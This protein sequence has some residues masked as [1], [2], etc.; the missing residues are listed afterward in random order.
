M[1]RACEV[2]QAG[3]SRGGRTRDSLYILNNRLTSSSHAH[4][5]HTIPRLVIP[6]KLLLQPGQE[7]RTSGTG[8]CRAGL[9]SSWEWQAAVHICGAETEGARRAGERGIST[10]KDAKHALRACGG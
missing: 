3:G 7:D 1:S 8:I 6:T 2:K 4:P 10:G 5:R 9:V